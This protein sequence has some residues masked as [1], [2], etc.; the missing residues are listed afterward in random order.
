M[1][2]ITHRDKHACQC[3]A[4]ARFKYAME[5]IRKITVGWLLSAYSVSRGYCKQKKMLCTTLQDHWRNSGNKL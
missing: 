1:W 4:F 3:G 2:C 5:L